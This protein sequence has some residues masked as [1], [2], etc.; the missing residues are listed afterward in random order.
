MTHLSASSL[1]LPA[2]CLL[3]LLLPACS[4][5][6]PEQP[7]QRV[8]DADTDGVAAEAD[9]DDAD[10][11][12]GAVAS[13]ADCDRTLTADDCDDADPNLNTVDADVD[14][15]STCDADCD[16]LDALVNPAATDGLLA[17]SDCVEGVSSNS[18]SR[19]EYSFTGESAEDYA[20]QKVASA[21]DVDGDGLG[22]FLVS[23][24]GND[25]AGD[26][27]GKA[28]LVLGASLDGRRAR[29]LGTADYAFTGEQASDSV[30]SVASAGD[31]DGDG[32]D[33]IL[34]GANNGG[35]LTGKGYLI[36]GASLGDSS[37]IDL[38]LADYSFVEEVAGDSPGYAVASAGDV[39]GDG[40]ADILLGAYYSDGGGWSSGKA[41]LFLGASLGSERALNLANAD[42][43]FV[44]EEGCMA[45]FSVSSAGDL[46]GDGGDDIL[47]GSIG[48]GTVDVVLASSLGSSP[49]IDLSLADYS[50]DAET[51]DDMVGWT[52]TTAGDVDGDGL[53]D[54]LIGGH[55]HDAYAGRAY[56][57]L[58][59]N[60]TSLGRRDLSLSDYIFDA[61]NAGD[62]AGSG[63]SGAGDVD[64]DGLDDILIGAYPN[65]EGG[66][67]AGKAYLVLGSSLGD[68]S[69]RSLSLADYAFVGE[70]AYDGAGIHVSGAGD[71]DGDG[72]DDVLI[73]AFFSDSAAG[74]AYV[75]LSRL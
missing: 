4:P 8:T 27:A 49:T 41:Y 7:E 63:L 71:V 65:S 31:V 58:G 14:G 16:D 45:G 66:A 1:L 15:Y 50:F 38:G 61:E 35:Q 17:D 13:D 68:V 2:T 62:F 19:A 39:D 33:D 24:A 74:R 48:C 40:L 26:R 69:T 53:A 29:S 11:A 9:C 43:A 75:I 22:D 28:Y 72:R 46:D 51:D 52:A 20:G 60:L 55:G 44:G 6:T 12:L 18:L 5:K 67:G 30:I 10:A 34:V 54:L 64:A 32:L 21:G 59:A 57:V 23:S 42:Y 3:A 70:A 37:V 47:V 36:L 56:L 73:G 25:E